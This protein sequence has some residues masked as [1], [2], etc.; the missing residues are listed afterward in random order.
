MPVSR[1][2]SSLALDLVNSFLEDA[3]LLQFFVQLAILLLLASQSQKLFLLA[4]LAEALVLFLD[5]V[6]E[7]A[8]CSDLMY[9]HL[10]VRF[11]LPLVLVY[12]LLLDLLVRSPPFQARVLGL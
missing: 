10:D 6:L 12:V 9:F 5:G 1:R 11:L 4:L 7:P 3:L 2:H 8:L